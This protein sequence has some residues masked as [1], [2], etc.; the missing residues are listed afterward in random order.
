LTLPSSPHHILFIIDDLS[1][2]GGAERALF[3]IVRSLSA[4]EFR[5]TV[6][7]FRGG[8]LADPAT[9]G[10]PVRVLPLTKTYDWNAL[11]VARE[12]HRFV[13]RENVSIVHTFFATADL[14]AGP[15]AKLSGCRVLISS[16]RDL[17]ILRSRKHS[18]GYKV[19]RGMYDAVFAVSPQVREFCIR[20]DGLNP[21]RVRTVF[22]GVDVGH[23]A[24]TGSRPEIR[25]ELGIPESARV[26]TT[27]ANI[28][29]VKGIDILVEA[30]A[31]VQRQCPEARFLVVGEKWEADYCRELEKRFAELDLVRNFQLLGRRDDVFPILRAS[32]VFCLPSR[33]EGFSNALIEAMACGLPCVAS[34]VGG[35]VEVVTDGTTGL[36]VP[37]ENSGELAMALLR[38]L[39]DPVLRSALGSRGEELVRR[40][41]TN[42]ATMSNLT[43]VYR[44]LIERRAT[45]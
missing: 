18:A 28:R 7:T 10:C 2:I 25:R 45:A 34:A 23:A 22:N 24:D 20:E 5:C 27:V 21:A 15:I 13:R 6:L 40:R 1:R 3:R 14:W 43:S 29:R 12:I 11:R 39:A 9:V 31:T 8:N 16:R 44:S 36:L 37:P 42:E 38:L 26:I 17:G 33:S 32:D 30:A 4:D 35:N 19:L 41:F